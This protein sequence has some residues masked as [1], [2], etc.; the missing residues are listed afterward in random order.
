LRP[1]IRKE[2]R[3]SIAT[4]I[5]LRFLMRATDKMSMFPRPRSG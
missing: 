2:S 3:L 1:S 4:T 5:R